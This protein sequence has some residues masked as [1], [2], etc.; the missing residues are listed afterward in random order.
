[1]QNLLPLTTQFSLEKK[2]RLNLR[3]VNDESPSAVIQKIIFTQQILQE[4]STENHLAPIFFAIENN[5]FEDL[6]ALIETYPVVL[7]QKYDGALTPIFFAIENNN[8]EALRIIIETHP[9]T[10]NQTDRD[11]LTPIFATIIDND[12]E[13]LKIIIENCSD[14]LEQTYEYSLTPIFFVLENN[15]L[16]ALKIITERCQEV[17]KQKHEEDLTPIFFAIEDN[18]LKALKI[19][20]EADPSSLEQIYDGNLTPIFFVINDAYLEAIEVIIEVY[21]SIL[22]QEDENKNIPI[23]KI[24][25][26]YDDNPHEQNKN[27]LQNIFEQQFKRKL[28]NDDIEN[29]VNFV[30]NLHLL[31]LIYEDSGQILKESNLKK[32]L[33]SAIILDD[34]KEDDLTRELAS[35]YQ[36]I[37]QEKIS[38]IVFFNKKGEQNSLR[39]YNS[40]IK[41]H[42]SYFIFHIDAE[43]KLTAIS[44]CDGNEVYADR[45]IES[46]NYINGATTYV[47][48]DQKEISND[49][50]R[51]Y[52]RKNFQEKDVDNLYEKI[53]EIDCI[54]TI[55]SIPT[56]VQT[57]ENCTFKSVNVL[58][59]FLLEHQRQETIFDFDFV[60]LR[61]KGIG[62]EAYKRIKEKMIQNASENLIVNAKKLGEDFCD[63]VK[64]SENIKIFLEKSSNKKTP[65][66]KFSQSSVEKLTNFYLDAGISHF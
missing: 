31:K 56:K 7:N 62:H 27:F 23:I 13:A 2:C 58:V 16:E 44:Y 49:F 8:L 61:P 30:R 24:V 38:E 33:H 15:N 32:I 41:D 36:K 48:K 17:L 29:L 65:A 47:L 6:K 40:E 50:A 57:K 43:N 14:I 12:L 52:I 45:K 53:S 35:I 34:Y 37:S 10:L 3:F 59:R 60:N 26:L 21:P 25:E 4:N 11:G 19:I 28:A 64:L 66:T 54:A 18:N 9:E 22:T 20:I 63:Q 55:F 51:N 42:S 1:M 5:N 46:T 39:I